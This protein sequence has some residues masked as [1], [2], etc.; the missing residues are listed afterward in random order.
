MTRQLVV[1]ADDL[2]LG[3][4]TNAAVVDLL[5]EGR[6]L[7]ATTL[8][9]VAPG[10]ADAVARVRSAG[11]AAPRLHVTMTSAREMSPWRPLATDVPTLTDGGGTFH[12]AL[13]RL[14]GTA[15][16]VD[17][18]REMT[19]QL[20]WMR[21][22]GLPP[23]ALDSHSGILYG[24]RGKSLLTTAIDFCA[25]HSLGFRLPRRLPR[26]VDLAWR[27]RIR[28]RYDE[29]VALAAARGVRLPETIVG[30]WL[31]GRL[32]LGYA[33]LRANVLSQLRQLPDGVSELILHPAPEGVA[34]RLDPAEGRKRVWE[35]RL[36]RDP[37]F[38]R[39]LRSEG[40]GLV[41]AW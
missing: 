37:L 28:R 40:I 19:A 25:E 21:D 35:L 1:T 9:T 11:I 8:M 17:V 23:A 7:T 15:T 22:A 29:G 2:G 30:C 12:A 20:A 38:L 34:R 39:T 4:Q 26:L 5:A 3:P 27:G 41:P 10:A 18:A 16:A 24:A 14:T 31:P 6:A 32:L 36:L 13:G 33:Q